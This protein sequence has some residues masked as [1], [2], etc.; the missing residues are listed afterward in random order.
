MGMQRRHFIALAVSAGGLAAASTTAAAGPSPISASGVDATQLGVRS[1]SADEQTRALQRAIDETA[2]T[3][4]PL[5]L[6]PGIYR[7]SQ[8][9]LSTGTHLVGARGATRLLLTQGDSLISAKGAD[10]V[11]ISGLVLD[12]AG[13]PLPGR[14]GLVQLESC[15]DVK[16]ADCTIT[17]SGSYGIICLAVAGE[18]SDNTIAQA[19][20]AAV[21]TL[22]SAGLLIARNHIDRAGDN[23]IQ[24]WRSIAGDDGTL[25]IDNRVENIGNRSGGSGQ[26]G[27]AINVFRAGNV[28]VR[29]NRI[30]NCAFSAVRGN[31]ASNLQIDG[32]SISNTREVALYAEFGFE[33]AMIASNSVEL[34]AVGISVTN[35]NEGGRLAV[36]QG[37][38]IRNLLPRRP[39][40]TDPGD[41]AGVGISVEAD[42]AVTGN[43]IENAPTAG[44]MLGW[45][46][47]LR[48]VAV[49]GNVVRKADIGI[50]VSV[51]PGAGT[52]LIANNVISD[53]VRGAIVGMARANPVTGDLSRAGAEQYAHIALTGNRVR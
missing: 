36:V 14:R 28:I 6:A 46:H 45:G 49:T 39:A 12:G 30:N 38:I 9:R 3:G 29:G 21:F 40:G 34:A 20:D 24:V 19:V 50:A 25:V 15:K 10:H 47:Y 18:L 41:A 11:T 4:T 43:V 27:N 2:R 8:L 5:A 13:H 1:G 42:T 48:D 7:T 53:T 37:N 31:A 44:M 17:G 51:D 23:G 35:F 33:G 52:A 22:D 26:Y 16:V 32:N